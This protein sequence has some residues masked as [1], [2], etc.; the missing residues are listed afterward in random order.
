MRERQQNTINRQILRLAIPNIISNLSVPLLSSAD[1]AILGHLDQVYYLGA[2][3]IGGVIF[4]FI[5]WG[6]GF[7]RM[8]TTGLTAQAHGTGNDRDA[9]L[10]L[11]RTLLIALTGGILLIALQAYI[12]GTSFALINATPE[13]EK[14]AL[15]YFYIR[16]YAAPATLLLYAFLTVGFSACRT[17]NTRSCSP[18]WQTSSISF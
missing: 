3:A 4:N 18:C 12:A 10:I 2:L 16:I 9:H 14:Y 8:G 5:Y 17:P 7:L 6:F 13:V 15:E 11:A 1:T